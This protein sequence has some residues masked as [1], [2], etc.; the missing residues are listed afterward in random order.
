MQANRSW[1]FGDVGMLQVDGEGSCTCN[2]S[3]AGMRW[4]GS[5]GKTC[6]E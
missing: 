6:L 3:R 1:S 2:G 5:E 4:W